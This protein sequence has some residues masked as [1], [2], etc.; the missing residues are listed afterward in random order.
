LTESIEEYRNQM[1]QPENSGKCPGKAGKWA[2]K[3]N[4]RIGNAS[5]LKLMSEM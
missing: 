4:L 3:S 5:G 1:I 2:T